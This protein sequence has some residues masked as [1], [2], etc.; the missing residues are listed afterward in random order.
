LLGLLLVSLFNVAYAADEVAPA[1]TDNSNFCL[2][3][4]VPAAEFKY[5]VV[6]EV[7]FAKGA[8]GGVKDVL[9]VFVAQAKAAGADAVINYAGTQRFGLFPW[10]LVRP[11]LRGTAI[12]W[13]S[14]A[15]VDCAKMGGMTM[16]AVIETNKAPDAAP[17]K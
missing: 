16:Q 11:V 1:A 17:A 10:R 12:K 9:P 14:A 13:D 7:K 6:T 3:A 5:T 8:Y 15:P 2:F 4:T